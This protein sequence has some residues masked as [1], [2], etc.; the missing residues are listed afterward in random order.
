MDLRFGKEATVGS[1]V[2]VAILVFIFGTIWLSGR[3]VSSGNIVMIQFADVSGLKRASPVRVSGFA[4]GKVEKIDFVDVGKVVATVSLPDKIHPKVDASAQIVSVT[5]VGDYAVD[6]NPG[7]AAEPLP[8][9]RL[10]VGSQKM[11]FTDKAAGLTDRADSVLIGAQALVNQRTA[12]QLYATMSSLQRTLSAAQRTMEIYGNP[13]RGPTAELTRS[14]GTFRGLAAR[15]DST[16]ADPRVQRALQR[17]DSLTT[18]FAQTSAQFARTGATLDSILRGVQAGEGTIGKFAK[19][20]ALY[21]NVVHLT[22]SM[23]S[24]I[25]TIRTNPGKITL[26]VPVKIF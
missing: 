1:L 16:L 23:D 21:R 5:L 20:S 9:G 14:M 24:L 4:V 26:Y 13:N 2:I 17:S 8:K 12:D 3:S 19:D 6:L 11:G 7:Q 22:A 15:L 25:N 18:N 10:I